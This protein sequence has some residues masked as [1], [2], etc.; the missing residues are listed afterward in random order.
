MQK[1]VGS[2]ADNKNIAEIYSQSS[3]DVSFSSYEIASNISKTSEITA[4]S[5]D[6]KNKEEKL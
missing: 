5:D 3:S 6:G 2:S 1:T 4:E